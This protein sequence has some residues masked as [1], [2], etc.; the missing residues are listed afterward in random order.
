MERKGVIIVDAAE[1]L[2]DPCGASSLPF[3][4]TERTAVAPHMRVVRDAGF[5]PA[6][7]ERDEPYFKLIHHMRELPH[8]Q[9]PPGLELVRAEPGD[10]ARHIGECYRR[11][12]ISEAELAA[13]RS[14]PVY[15]PALWIAVAERETRRIVASAIGEL[16]L[17]IGEG[18]LEWVQVSPDCRR[19]GLGRFLVCE[20][21]RRMEGRAQFV[22][23]SGRMRNETE[24]LALYLA[25]GFSDPAIWHVLTRAE[26][27]D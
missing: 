25:C 1:Y 2:L 20:L 13:Y 7:G 3:W 16:D 8:A 15:D 6:P 4:K 12:G 21:L 14:H 24:P 27:D 26:E 17:R 10:F 9:L 11:E 22:T 23:A 5:A 19:R 18:V